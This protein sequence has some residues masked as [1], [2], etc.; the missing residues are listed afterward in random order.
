[1]SKKTNCMTLDE[2]WDPT[3]WRRKPNRREVESLIAAHA[4]SDHI[5]S[6]LKE[7]ALLHIECEMLRERLAIQTD[8][9]TD[10]FHI[11]NNKVNHTWKLES[12]VVL[13]KKD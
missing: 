1:M 7:L 9:L 6:D 3:A 4:A 5:G 10:A 2:E 11:A 8:C 12:R 13:E